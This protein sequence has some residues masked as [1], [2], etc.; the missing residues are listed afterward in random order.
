MHYLRLRLCL[1]RKEMFGI[2]GHIYQICF[3]F[4]CRISVVSVVLETRWSAQHKLKE[5]SRKVK[6]G[7]YEVLVCL[8]TK[9]HAYT[10]LCSIVGVLN[11]NSE[12]PV[13]DIFRDM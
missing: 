11:F 3:C 12:V 8:K 4:F 2:F 6:G 5:I 7:W 9:L 13:D 1:G 10:N